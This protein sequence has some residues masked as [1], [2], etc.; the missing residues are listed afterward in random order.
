VNPQEFCREKGY[1]AALL[2]TYDFDPLFFER[3]VLRNLWLG[4]T[5]DVTVVADALRIAISSA[6]WPS[7]LRSLGRKYQLVPAD[8]RGA[9]HPK[10]ILRIG[11]EG[12]AT[13]ALGLGHFSNESPPGVPRVC[14][15]T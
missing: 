15:T 13:M 6:R 4:Q 14:N 5:G 7:Q 9:F 11:D 3:V 8:T 1:T 12:G 10:I 2:L